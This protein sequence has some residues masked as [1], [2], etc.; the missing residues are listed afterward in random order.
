LINLAPEVEEIFAKDDFEPV[1][2]QLDPDS[3]SKH[4]LILDTKEEENV[5]YLRRL[6]ETAGGEL[7]TI[8]KE[9]ELTQTQF[10]A[11]IEHIPA[12]Q[13]GITQLLPLKLVQKTGILTPDACVA[14]FDTVSRI[15]KKRIKFNKDNIGRSGNLVKFQT[16]MKKL[17]PKEFL[18]QAI[19]LHPNTL[20]EFSA[21]QMCAKLKYYKTDEGIKNLLRNIKRE[22]SIMEKGIGA[23]SKKA[24]VKVAKRVRDLVEKTQGPA[25]RSKSFRPITE[26]IPLSSAEQ[27]ENSGDDEEMDDNYSD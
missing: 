1:K 18:K 9:C 19:E 20:R 2:Y 23:K 4:W 16:E 3:K 8:Q 26:D 17:S 15:L 21:E 7:V 14:I 13:N 27:A 11:F 6:K 10:E 22:Y 5:V 24:P 25:G 12:I